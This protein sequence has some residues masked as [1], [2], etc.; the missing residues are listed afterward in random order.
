[1]SPQKYQSLCHCVSWQVL[2]T[3]RFI[4]AVLQLSVILAASEQMP[5]SA[6]FWEEVETVV[7]WSCSEPPWHSCPSCLWVCLPWGCCMWFVC[8]KMLCWALAIWEQLGR[9]QSG[10]QEGAIWTAKPS[11]LL[12]WSRSWSAKLAFC[13]GAS[14]VA[15]GVP[16]SALGL[17]ISVSLR[18]H[19]ASV[20]C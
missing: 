19:W 3:E 2:S 1:M 14:P 18:L 5:G 7:V 8:L 10:W 12:R 6:P 20:S 17:Q 13:F 16:V 9:L 11:F 4:S 15:Q